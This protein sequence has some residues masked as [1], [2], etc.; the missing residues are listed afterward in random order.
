MKSLISASSTPATTPSP[1]DAALPV[2]CALVWIVPPPSASANV[3]VAFA[4]PCPPASLDLTLSTV[5]MGGRVL[6]DDLDGARERHRHRAHLHLD[7][8]LDRVGT[9]RLEHRSAL[10]ARHHALEVGDGGEAVVDRPRRRERVLELYCHAASS[11]G[12]VS[13]SMNRLPR[14]PIQPG[15]YKLGPDNGTLVGADQAHRRRGQGGAQ[16]A[17]HVTA[18]EAT[19]R[20]ATTRRASSSTADAT[21]LRVREGT[22][23]MQAL[24]DD[25]KANI[26]QTIDD[27][28]L[29]RQAITFRSTAVEAPPTATGSTSQG[30]LTLL[31]TTRPLAFDVAVAGDGTLSAV[32]VVKQT[33][34]GD[35]ALLGAVRRAEGRRRGRGRLDA[36]STEPQSR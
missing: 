17:I 7:L 36:A 9:G 23:G 19:L 25:D 16:P 6:L 32:A 4:W 30:E 12:R 15:T 2:I 22:G 27:E 13:E 33:R 28:V 5:R 26:E 18:W 21:S 8:G 20:S 11:F 14:V 34:L 29:K 10:D 31:G 24:G 35:E 3:T 1:I